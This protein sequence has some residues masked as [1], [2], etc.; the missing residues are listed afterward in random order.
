[1]LGNYQIIFKLTKNTRLKKHF[2][3]KYIHMGLY[4][5]ILSLVMQHSYYSSRLILLELTHYKYTFSCRKF[6][7]DRFN[8][9]GYQRDLFNFHNT[10][11]TDLFKFFFAHN[12]LRIFLLDPCFSTFWACSVLS[13]SECWA[14]KTNHLITEFRRQRL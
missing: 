3:H 6:M 11:L 10:F 14:Y 4:S 1:M 2:W 8:F 12:K 5:I 9:L 13:T 7:F